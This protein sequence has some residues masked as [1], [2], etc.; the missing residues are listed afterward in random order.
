MRTRKFA[1]DINWPLPKEMKIL[2]KCNIFEKRVNYAELSWVKTNVAISTISEVI[3]QDTNFLN[4]ILNP[5]LLCGMVGRQRY[6]GKLWCRIS[7]TAN[8]L[9]K[10]QWIHSTSWNLTYFFVLRT[11]SNWAYFFLY[12]PH[13]HSRLKCLGGLIFGWKPW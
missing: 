3:R 12:A 1:F 13:V 6:V 9:A 4:K 11:S 7:L 5:G 10:C 8:R 2:E